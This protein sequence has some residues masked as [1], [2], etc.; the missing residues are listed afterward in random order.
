[1]ERYQLPS[2]EHVP[3]THMYAHTGEPSFGEGSSRAAPPSLPT[4]GSNSDDW[5]SL[6]PTRAAVIVPA[7]YANDSDEEHLASGAEDLVWQA[8]APAIA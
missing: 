4:S 3:T 8:M 5:S 7:D 2:P 6:S 1:M